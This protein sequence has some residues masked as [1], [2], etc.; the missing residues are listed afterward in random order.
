MPTPL[1]AAAVL[2]LGA[3]AFAGSGQQ[4]P[5][6]RQEQPAR[7]EPVAVPTGDEAS[8]LSVLVTG[9]LLT[10]CLRSPPRAS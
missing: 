7:V 6:A 5:A 9:A 3:V 8:W 10:W 4:A 1:M 2:G